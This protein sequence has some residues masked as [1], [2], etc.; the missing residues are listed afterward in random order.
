VG[1]DRGHDFQE[2]L[3][4]EFMKP[5][6]YLETSVISYLASRPSRDLIMAAHQQVTHEWWEKRRSKFELVVSQLVLQE[7]SGGDKSAAEQRNSYVEDLSQ[8][9]VTD[10]VIELA[11]KLLRVSA[12]PASEFADAVHV[13]AAAVHGI[14]Y[15]LTWNLKHIANAVIRHRIESTCRESGYE[16]PV[17]CTPEELLE[18]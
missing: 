4:N 2:P 15:L 12:I 7:A 6:V 18:E 17:I 10:A 11:Q 13:A 8:V 5:K 1:S 3:Y 14:D 9:Q 16:P